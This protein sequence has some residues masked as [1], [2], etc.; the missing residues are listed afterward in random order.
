MVQLVVEQ[1]VN[2]HPNKMCAVQLVTQ[3]VVSS[4]TAAL[5][6]VSSS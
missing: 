6:V 2:K 3:F 4:C 1:A 5:Y